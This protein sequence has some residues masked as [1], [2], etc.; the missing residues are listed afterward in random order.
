MSN[1][2]L[3]V[4]DLKKY[5]PAGQGRT[6]HAVDGVNM[7]I[8]PGR[9]LGVVGESGCGKSTL[10]RTILRLTEPTAGQILLDGE[11]ITKLSP[12]KLRKYRTKMQIIFQD[13]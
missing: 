1:W 3:E 5:F 12:S 8:Q 11:D 7:R 9:T 2:L 10:G 13:P 4:N 6:L